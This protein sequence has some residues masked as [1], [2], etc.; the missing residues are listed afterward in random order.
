MHD[1]H[2][3]REHED[4]LLEVMGSNIGSAG[5]QGHCCRRKREI[6]LVATGSDIFR[7]DGKRVQFGGS[8]LKVSGLM[9]VGLT[10]VWQAGWTSA[11]PVLETSG[12]GA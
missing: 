5:K 4:V 8:S 9:E 7:G 11:A 6:S 3:W 2:H 12:L 10:W 1:L